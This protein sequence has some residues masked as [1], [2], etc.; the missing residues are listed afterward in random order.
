ME[1]L[2]NQRF[3]AERAL[4]GSRDVTL[5]RCAFDGPADGESALKESG[6]VTAEDCF[7][8]LRYPLW[9]VDGLTLKGCEL[10]EFCRAALWYSR[11]G[12]IRDS[13]LHGIKAL[14]E[15]RDFKLTG[16]DIVSP[17][18][19]WS[20]R[21]VEMVRCTARSEYFMLRAS[22]LTLRDV[23]LTGKYSFQ[24]VENALLEDCVLDTKDAFWHTRNVT[25]RN[26]VVKGEYLGWYSEGLTLDHCAITGTQPLCYCKGLKLID[27]AMTGADLAFERSE[28]EAT[29]TTFIDSVKNPRAGHI[30]LPGLGELIMDDPLARGE[31]LLTGGMEGE[32]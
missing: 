8:N 28:V 22:G 7:F 1:L 27:C 18:F 23:T 2:E 20:S 3:D 32:G 21:E 9:H 26:S 25:V 16:C 14:R 30:R 31:V 15:C 24:Y 29:V 19:G 10:T 17:E 13:K 5:R 4:Y 6:R 11:G 12:D